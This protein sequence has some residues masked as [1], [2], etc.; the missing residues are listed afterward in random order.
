MYYNHTLMMAFGADCTAS[1]CTLLI[2][3]KLVLTSTPILQTIFKPKL[4][5]IN[6]S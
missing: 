4:G 2:W 3:A 5:E 6:R 1:L